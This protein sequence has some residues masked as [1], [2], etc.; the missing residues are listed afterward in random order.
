MVRVNIRE[1]K[2]EEGLARAR[3]AM[4]IAALTGTNLTTHDNDDILAGTVY[5][6][7]RL[8]HQYHPLPPSF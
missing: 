3:A 2:R 5:R 7:P 8:F 1:E 6:N 4:R